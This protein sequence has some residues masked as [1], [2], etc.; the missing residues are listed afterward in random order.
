MVHVTVGYMQPGP[1]CS[2]VSLSVRHISYLLNAHQEA[3]SHIISYSPI[4]LLIARKSTE[5]GCP[6]FV[7]RHRAASLLSVTD[8]PVGP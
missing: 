6:F 8:Q 7:G 1:G 5:S 3:V 4:S 2:G